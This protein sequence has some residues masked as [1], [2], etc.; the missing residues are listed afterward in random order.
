LVQARLR[1]ADAALLTQR[2]RTAMDSLAWRSLRT[3]GN[4][5]AAWLADLCLSVASAMR[6]RRWPFPVPKLQPLLL[7]LDVAL[8]WAEPLTSWP[9]Q[10]WLSDQDGT[11]ESPVTR[12]PSSSQSPSRLSAGHVH[13]GEHSRRFTSVLRCDSSF[14]ITHADTSMLEL[15]EYECHELIG[16]SILELMSPVVADI[17]RKIFRNLKNLAPASVCVVGK[18]L[19]GSTMSR[20]RE[21]AVLDANKEA[22]MCSVSVVLRKDLSSKVRLQNTKGK[23]LHTVPLGFGRFIN[24]KPGV[25]VQEFEE[26]ICVMMDIAGS[27]KFSRSKLPR[28]MAELYHRM[29]VIAN[30]VALQEAFPFVYIHEIVGDSLLLLVNAGFMVRYPSKAAAIGTHVAMRI[31]HRL[32]IMLA[33]YSPEMYT[34]TGISIGPVTAGVVD[35]RTF[36]VFGSTVHLSQ[37]LESLCPRSRVACSTDFLDVLRRQADGDVH[38]D[39]L[40]SE[41]KGVGHMKYATLQ[42]D[43]DRGIKIVNAA[44]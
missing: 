37:R 43:L 44:G 38:V 5:L 19:L 22:V 11:P 9:S 20:C 23:V 17:H 26:V 34:R 2:S 28:V 8:A 3:L 36:R 7:L 24:A 29:Y 10:T 41:V 21:F 35:G 14:T 4:F 39:L 33:S 18:R 40:E 31:Q 32:D 15:L 6:L 42:G 30:S 1:A 25:H 13:S 12:D 27:T 16:K